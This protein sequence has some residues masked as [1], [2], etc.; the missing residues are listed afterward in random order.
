MPDTPARLPINTNSGITVRVKVAEI[1]KVS[2]PNALKAAEY[3][4]KDAV[5]K[6]PTVNIAIATG[7][8]RNN[9]ANNAKRPI[10]PITVADNHPSFNYLFLSLFIS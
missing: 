3:P 4:F 1:S 9:N 8:R 5:P 6:N 7:T 2:V 10:N